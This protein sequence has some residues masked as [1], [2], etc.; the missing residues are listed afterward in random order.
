MKKIITFLT[1]YLIGT[2]SFAQAPAIQ[3]QKCLGG[4][5]I[6]MASAIQNTTDGGYIIAGSTTESNDGDVSGNHGFHDGWVVKLSNAG[7]LQWQKTLGGVFDDNL[8]AIQKTSD[9]GYIVIGTTTSSDINLSGIDGDGDYFI[10]KISTSGVVEW[11]KALGGTSNEMGLNIVQTT[12]GGY[13]LAGQTNSNDGNVSGNHGNGDAWVVKLSNSGNMEWQKCFGGT[14]NDFASSIQQTSDNGF[15]L[16]GTTGSNDGNVSGNH[17]SVD[18]WVVK[19]SSSGNLEWQKSLGGTFEDHA[20]SIKQTQNGGYI[21]T[22]YTVSIDGD[23]TGSNGGINAWVVKLSL[24]GDIQWQKTF[25]GTSY[26]YAYSIQLA[27][28]GGY[29]IAGYTQSNDGD[30]SGYHGVGDVWVVKLS[31]IGMIQWQKC[32]G[33]TSYDSA[34]CIQPTADG[35]YII[36]G[37]TYSTNGNVS[38][39]HGGYDAWVVKLGPELATSTFNNQVLTLYPNPTKG[40]LQLQTPNNTSFNQIII[41]DSTGKSVLEQTQNTTQVDVEQLASG[42]YFIKAFS[43][44][45]VFVNKFVKE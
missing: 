10:V 5:G 38:G 35:G 45:E 3:W 32:L 29:I 42:L 20:K 21:L 17:G 39:N 28:D 30:V 24:L 41:T 31:N 37:E 34:T 2:L 23:V 15:I 4:T 26:D 16:A 19:L 40:L 33:G 11:Q 18:A 43:G 7:I 9:G 6:E 36:T 14:A 22:G 25:G 13:I 8:N 1:L 27:T 12:D 44:E